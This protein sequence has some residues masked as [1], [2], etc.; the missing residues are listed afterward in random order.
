VL[1]LSLGFKW[2]T[3]RNV[4]VSTAASLWAGQ[5]RK[6]GSTPGRIKNVSLL[7]RVQ[8]VYGVDPDCCLMGTWCSFAGS[9]VI[10]A[11]HLR[12]V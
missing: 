12:L 10:K 9:E 5:L 1:R 6:L 3:N 2:F 8:T 11:T 7:G 4:V